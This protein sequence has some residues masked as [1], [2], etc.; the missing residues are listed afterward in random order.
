MRS[1]WPS[2]SQRVAAW[3]R[4]AETS[5]QSSRREPSASDTDTWCPSSWRYERS[6]CGDM[7]SL[8]RCPKQSFYVNHH[9]GAR[10]PDLRSEA[11]HVAPGDRSAG[12]IEDHDDVAG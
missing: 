11:D 12:G 4:P 9:F 1:S 2:W 3:P 10:M 5:S 8:L 7:T 6:A